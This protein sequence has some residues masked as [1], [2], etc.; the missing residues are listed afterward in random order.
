MQTIRMTEAV[1]VRIDPDLKQWLQD[2]AAS[3]E[4]SINM[5]IRRILQRERNRRRQEDDAAYAN[6]SPL[7]SDDRH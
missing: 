5:I 7:A 2:R 4:R 1:M 3:E 6:N